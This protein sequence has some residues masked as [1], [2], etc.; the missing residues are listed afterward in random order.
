MVQAQRASHSRLRGTWSRGWCS[1][2]ARTPIAALLRGGWDTVG[3]IVEQVVADH[4]GR[5]RLEGW[6]TIG[7]DET[8]YRRGQRYLATAVDHRKGAIVWC[9]PGRNARTLKQFSGARGPQAV[10]L[11]GLG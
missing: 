8:S 9:A 5:R 7:V 10:D 11:S 6:V 3:K 1:R 4:I 2:C